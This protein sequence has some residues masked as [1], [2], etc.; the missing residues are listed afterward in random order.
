MIVVIARWKRHV[1]KSQLPP[2]TLGGATLAAFRYVRYSPGIRTLLLRSACVIFFSSAFW[3][4]LP[5]VARELSKSSVGYGLLL[6]FFG[7]GAVIGA[8]VLQ[9]ARKTAS[10][11]AVVS[12]ATIVFGGVVLAVA[13]LHSLWILCVFMSF[14]GAAWTVFMSVFNTL[15]QTLAPDW[16]RARVLAIYLFV[17]QGSVAVGSAI[18]GFAATHTSS[19][20]AL[21][22]SGVGIGTCLLL[23]F[24]LRLPDAGLALDVWNHWKMPTLFAEPAPD[25]GPVLVTV[26]HRVVLDRRSHF[27]DAIHEYQRVRRRDGATQW[28]CST[29]RR[30]R[31]GISRV[32]SSIPG[33]HT[34]DSMIALQWRIA[35]WK[36][37]SHSM[38]S[39]LQ[40]FDISST[41]RESPVSAKPDLE[42]RANPGR[43]PGNR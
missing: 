1:R 40:R 28:G 42:Q 36:I 8:I 15:A 37:E 27:L 32:F 7:M 20:T 35:N 4:L 5:A 31:A 22:F 11:E 14:G 38:C 29:M 41:R 33:Q 43:G 9:R 2:E 24:P 25:Q 16:V 17:F 26:E 23:R 30:F 18:W 6:G 10:V 3:A 39:N 34:N 19:H 13:T 21:L 12:A